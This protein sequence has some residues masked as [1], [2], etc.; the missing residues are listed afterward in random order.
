M[1]QITLSEQR[2]VPS[3]GCPLFHRKCSWS[4][5]Q[6]LWLI[7]DRTGIRGIFRRAS[8]TGC[9]TG[10][11]GEEPGCLH[12]VSVYQLCSQPSRLA[13]RGSFQCLLSSTAAHVPRG[14]CCTYLLLAMELFL[15]TLPESLLLGP[16]QTTRM[17]FTM[18][19]N[20]AYGSPCESHLTTESCW[21]NN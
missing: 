20:I 3:G 5:L 11:E 9:F 8:P 4:E 12:S 7:W 13:P 6:T 19:V 10:S 15:F 17:G 14:L 1:T 18:L 21:P 2:L 16:L